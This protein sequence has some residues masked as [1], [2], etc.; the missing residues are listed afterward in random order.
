M[1]VLLE[2]FGLTLLGLCSVAVCCGVLA[3]IV[4][5]TPL[6][7]RQRAALWGVGR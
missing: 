2:V 1:I 3:I 5:L 6:L 4:S 7:D